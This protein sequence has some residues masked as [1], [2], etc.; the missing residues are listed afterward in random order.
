MPVAFLIRRLR[1]EGGDPLI[2]ARRPTGRHLA[3]HHVQRAAEVDRAV[4]E[5]IDS[6]VD[7]L[8]HLT[9][10]GRQALDQLEDCRSIAMYLADLRVLVAELALGRCRDHLGQQALV[11]VAARLD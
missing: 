1:L 9:L 3:I 5:A 6:L 7:V 4:V 8:E 2:D 11:G 10:R